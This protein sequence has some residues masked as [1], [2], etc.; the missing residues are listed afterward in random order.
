MYAS[1]GIPVIAMTT[2]EALIREIKP[3]SKLKSNVYSRQV[4]YPILF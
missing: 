4:L 1:E 3:L 2:F